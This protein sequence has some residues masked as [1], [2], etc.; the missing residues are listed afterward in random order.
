M[1]CHGNRATIVITRDF[2]ERITTSNDLIEKINK[3]YHLAEKK[4]K[5]YSPEQ[6]KSIKPENNNGV[7]F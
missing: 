3:K 1:Y 6:K 7:K 4:I 5:Y 2:I